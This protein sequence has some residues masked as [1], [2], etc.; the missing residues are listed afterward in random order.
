MANNLVNHLELNNLLYDNQY[1]FLRGHSTLHNVTKLT[2][3]IAQDLNEKKYVIGVFLD[4]KK[5][6]DTVSHKILLMKLKKLGI[7]GKALEWFTSYLSG[8]SQ[9]TEVSGCKSPELT[10]DISVL[11]GS[12]LGPILFLCFI[13]DLHLATWLLTLLFADDTAV[14]ASGANLD[15]LIPMVNL[16][17]QKIAN[18]F[19]SNKMSVNVSKT[20]YILFRPRGQKILH[21]LDENGII[22]NS[23][24]IGGNDDKSKIFKLG[25]IHNEHANIN[26]RTYKFLGVHLDEYLSFDTHCTIICNKLARSNFIISRVKNILPVKTLKTLY[27]SLIHP[28]LLYCL[29]IFSC[30]TQNFF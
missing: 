4:L 25:R 27:F 7:T 26:E 23:N 30:T 15:T 20:K 22:Y 12:I 29:P 1:G 6:F 13:N 21:N 5:A 17:I 11:Q 2:A 14:I 18:W 24:E 9:F 28:H 16:E 10:I 8:R 3:R 19:R